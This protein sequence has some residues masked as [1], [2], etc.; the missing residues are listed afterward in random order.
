VVKIKAVWEVYFSKNSSASL[1]LLN[2]KTYEEHSHQKLVA[3]FAAV[4]LLVLSLS[5]QQQQQQRL[6]LFA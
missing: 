1:V 2:T 3:R 6:A 5:G 4:V